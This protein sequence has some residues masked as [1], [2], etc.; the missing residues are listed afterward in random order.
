MNIADVLKGKIVVPEDFVEPLP[1]EE[2][3]RW[4]GA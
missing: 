3:E 2:L 4:E 1:E